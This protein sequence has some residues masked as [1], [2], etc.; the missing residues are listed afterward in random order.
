MSGLISLAA[1]QLSQYQPSSSQGQG[2][3]RQGQGTFA[4]P[5][6]GGGSGAVRGGGG[7]GGGRGGGGGGE[8]HQGLDWLRE[9]VPGE[10][11]VDYPVFSLP[12]PDNDFRSDSPP[13]V[14]S[15]EVF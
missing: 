8:D 6:P 14:S 9:S 3:S 4:R 11:G 10:P 15:S 2:G 12:V 5:A 1:G 13:L 7:G